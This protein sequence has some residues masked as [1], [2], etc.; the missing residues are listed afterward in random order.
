MKKGIMFA[1]IPAACLLAC[2]AR[3]DDFVIRK[4]D[5][6]GAVVITYRG[7]G[8]GAPIERGADGID[9]LIVNRQA[10]Q[11]ASHVLEF[12]FETPDYFEKGNSGHFAVGVRGYASE[13]KVVGHGVVIGNIS[14]YTKDSGPCKRTSQVN[15]VAIEDFLDGDTCVHG[16]GEY[17]EPTPF[18]SQQLKN[19]TRYKIRIG[20]YYVGGV[21]GYLTQYVLWERWSGKEIGRATIVDDGY[22]DLGQAG[23]LS[24]DSPR[25]SLRDYSLSP[26]TNGGWFILEVLN[27]SRWTFYIYNLKYSAGGQLESSACANKV[28]IYTSWLNDPR[29]HDRFLTTSPLRYKSAIEKY[30]YDDSKTVLAYVEPLYKAYTVPLRS[31]YSQAFQNHILSYHGNTAYKHR[32]GFEEIDYLLGNGW[33]EDDTLGYVYTIPLPGTTHLYRLWKNHNNSDDFEHRHTT[34]WGEV[35][36]LQGEGWEYDNI[37]EAYVCK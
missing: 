28:P 1:G 6:G 5:P 31:Y 18:E 3:A 29:R 11:F 33:V 22:D 27:S 34:D 26:R 7:G 12:E 23:L 25:D 36:R 35:V 15:V 20:S 10:G 19:N 37:F 14:G 2:F 4:P 13:K 16:G 21:A 24:S 9:R 8:R 32:Y 17:V 30:G